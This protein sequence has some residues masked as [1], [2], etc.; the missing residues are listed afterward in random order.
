MNIS[1]A[2]FMVEEFLLYRGFTQTFRCLENEKSHDR[3]RSLQEHKIVEQIFQYLTNFDI[4]S[5]VSLWDFLLKRFFLHL[6]QEH[7]EMIASLKA[8]LLKFYLVNTIKANNRQKAHEFFAA[9]SHEI[10]TEA[11]ELISASF[12]PWSV[13]ILLISVY[14]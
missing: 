12:R 1:N 9:Y 7:L 14:F 13:I 3:A 4:E 8:D 10:L 2:D 11:G 6:D 5:F